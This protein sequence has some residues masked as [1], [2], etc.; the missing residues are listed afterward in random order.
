MI[1]SRRWRTAWQRHFYLYSYS[2]E[3]PVLCLVRPEQDK[4]PEAPPPKEQEQQEALTYIGLNLV[5]SMDLAW[6][7]R[8]NQ[9]SG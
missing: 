3:P 9:L 7:T 6:L 1:R 5:G 8:S 4:Q 2:S